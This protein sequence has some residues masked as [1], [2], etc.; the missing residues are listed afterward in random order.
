MVNNYNSIYINYNVVCILDS[1]KSHSVLELVV[2]KNS[3]K[4]TVSE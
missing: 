4:P 2:W 3:N 1:Y